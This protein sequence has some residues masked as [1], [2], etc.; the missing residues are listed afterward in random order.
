[1]INLQGY[2][3]YNTAFDD[4]LLNSIGIPSD[5]YVDRAVCLDVLEIYVTRNKHMT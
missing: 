3:A 1:M 5:I 2:R 4:F